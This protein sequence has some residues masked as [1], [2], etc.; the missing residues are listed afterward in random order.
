MA[1]WTALTASVNGAAPTGD[2]W[3]KHAFSAKV[4][5][6][7]LAG[8]GK[9]PCFRQ[10]DNTPQRE[11][12]PSQLEEQKIQ[13]AQACTLGLK[14]FWHPNF[15]KALKVRDSQVLGR[16]WRENSKLPFI[17]K[18]ACFSAAFPD[19]MRNLSVGQFW[20]KLTS[21]LSEGCE[22]VEFEHPRASTFLC[23]G[24]ISV[25]R[26][27]KLIACSFLLLCLVHPSL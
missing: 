11:V 17:N 25:K 13:G 8:D 21:H 19:L 4:S 5:G 7:E 10:R 23:G 18:S 16:S 6:T 1:G 26:L 9:W 15:Y 27:L 12:T 20:P 14:L 24:I 22:A 3:L 2:L